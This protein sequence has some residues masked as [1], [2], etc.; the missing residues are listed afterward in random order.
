MPSVCGISNY[1]AEYAHDLHFSNMQ[2]N[3]QQNSKKPILQNLQNQLET[4][5]IAE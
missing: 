1:V 5:K 2:M 3:I 4:F